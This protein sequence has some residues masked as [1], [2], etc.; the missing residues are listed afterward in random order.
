MDRFK[1][2]TRTCSHPWCWGYV[3][4]EWGVKYRVSGLLQRLARRQARQRMKQRDRDDRRREGGGE[5]GND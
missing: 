1:T 3:C 4:H 2:L 5:D